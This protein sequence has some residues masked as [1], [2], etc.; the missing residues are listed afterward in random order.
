MQIR[1][2]VSTLFIMAGTA[3]F[4]QAAPTAPVIAT[5]G[6]T[7]SFPSLAGTLHYA[8]S[9]S[10]LAQFG[11]YGSG[12][13]TATTS[14]SGDAGYTSKSTQAPFSM[15]FAGGVL[16]TNESSVG[17]TTFLNLALSQSLISGRW[18][19]GITDS[20]SFL[21]QSPTS[22]LSGI[23]GVG[24]LG[25]QP[26]QG[27]SEG[28]AGGS[29]TTEG[30][31]VS[32]DLGGSAERLITGKTS[33]SGIGSWSI[34]RFLNDEDGLG[35]T[36]ILGQ[37]SVNHKI[38]ARDTISGNVSYSV[39]TFGPGE[40]GLS[41]HTLGL[42]V[43]GQR[44]VSR[45]FTVSGSIGPQW[46]SSSDSAVIPDKVIVGGGASVNYSRGY[47]NANLGYTRGVN[48]GSGLQAG[49]IND[50][51]SGSVART[52]DRVWLTSVYGTYTHMTGLASTTASTAPT[53]TD[54]PSDFGSGNT[55][56]VYGSIQ[57]S[58]KLG[59]YTSVFASYSLQHQSVAA[60]LVGQNAF[61]GTS[62]TVSVGITFSPRS[63][64]LGQF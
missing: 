4:G 64:H 62:Q 27:P 32:N 38:D 14:L 5:P 33:V 2:A 53:P 51:V 47:T 18:V 45:S 36:Q 31:R 35:N 6:S 22:G 20:V 39:Y 40:G 25:G 26:V 49:A 9:A 10:Q 12:Q 29:L 34:L 8:L 13:T 60:T 63:T 59:T 19:L 58:R 61:I 46:I 54:T 23:P 55:S 50:T 28:P 21:P 37:V 48:G 1:I 56:S 24:D 17:T 11:Y 57:A 43:S 3:A 15:L 42:N 16:F 41:L 44:I 52:F 30:S 7:M